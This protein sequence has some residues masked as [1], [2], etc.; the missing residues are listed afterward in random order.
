[1]LSELFGALPPEGFTVEA[2]RG[3]LEHIPETSTWFS[4]I[5][6]RHKTLRGDGVHTDAPGNLGSMGQQRGEE[7]WEEGRRILAC[8]HLAEPSPDE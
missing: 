7:E 6:S 5:V 4:R 3:Q 8:M 1:M 2:V